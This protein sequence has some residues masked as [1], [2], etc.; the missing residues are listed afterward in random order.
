MEIPGLAR[1]FIDGRNV[2]IDSPPDLSHRISQ[3]IWSRVSHL[4]AW[5]CLWNTVG[6]TARVFCVP[7]PAAFSCEDVIEALKLVFAPVV[8]TQYDMGIALSSTRALVIAMI[9]A[10]VANSRVITAAAIAPVVFVD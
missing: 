10:T 3:P 1:S 4:A 8:I 9:R 7:L 2:L 5:Q 6:T